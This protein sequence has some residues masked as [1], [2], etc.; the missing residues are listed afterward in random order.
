MHQCKKTTCVWKCYMGNT[1]IVIWSGPKKAYGGLS[2]CLKRPSINTPGNFLFG[3]PLSSS[4]PAEVW[5][6][7]A[8][9]CTV[10]CWALYF[11]ITSCSSVRS[12]TCARGTTWAKVRG[13][14]TTGIESEISA[15][16]WCTMWTVHFVSLRF[17]DMR[18]LLQ[19]PRT[20]FFF[21]QCK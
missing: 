8:R 1:Y 17:G 3:N 9:R 13:Q 2:C 21:L 5:L 15:R 4:H 18:Q 10:V 20:Y 14:Q 6:E 7:G 11:Y 19:E 12:T 16:G